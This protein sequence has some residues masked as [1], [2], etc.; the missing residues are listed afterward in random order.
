MKVETTVT[1][2]GDVMA[3]LDCQTRDPQLRRGDLGGV[4]EDESRDI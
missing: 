4:S 2:S 3:A 1:L